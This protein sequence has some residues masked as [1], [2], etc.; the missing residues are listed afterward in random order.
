[1]NEKYKKS[2]ACSLHKTMNH[3]GCGCGGNSDADYAN[4]Y[5]TKDKPRNLYKNNAHIKGYRK[6]VGG[7]GNDYSGAVVNE[8]ATMGTPALSGENHQVDELQ[9]EIWDLQKAHDSLKEVKAHANKYTHVLQ[10]KIKNLEARIVPE[11]DKLEQNIKKLE[12][13]AGN[14]VTK[15]E[16][17]RTKTSNDLADMIDKYQKEMNDMHLKYGDQVPPIMRIN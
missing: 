14:Y 4:I 8:E 3:G 6:M 9:K 13:T 10:E 11:I 12:K 5:N 17:S 7:D 16:E 1:M 2:Y 15:L